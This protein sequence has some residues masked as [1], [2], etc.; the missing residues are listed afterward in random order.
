MSPSTEPY[1]EEKYKALMDGLECS[2]I[3]LS[4]VTSFNAFRI[5]SH[6]FMK[7]YLRLCKILKALPCV[8][9]S[10]LVLKDIQT[11][12]TPSMANEKY[13]GGHIALIKTDNLHDNSIST[14]FSDYL[15]I[16]GN[17]V[18]SRTSLA[19]RDIITTIIG[20]TESVIA[21]S[22]IIT[23]EYLPA[24]INQN[25]VQI[26]INPEKASPEYIN[27][28]LNTKYG[29]NYMVYLSRQTEQY[30]LNCKEIEQVLVVML[31][32]AFQERITRIVR[33]AQ[34]LQTRQREFFEDAC[35]IV[36]HV[37]SIDFHFLP[38]ENIAIKSNKESFVKN[39]RFD[40]EY[41]QPFYEEI[42]KKINTKETI[43]SLCA[44]N[45]ET[46]LPVDQLEYKYIELSSVEKYGTVSDTEVLRGH[47]LPS[48]ARRRVYKGQVIVASVE[49]SLQS[50]ALID[51][52]NDNALCSTGFYVLKSETINPETLLVLFKSKP[53]QALLKQRCSGTILTAISQDELLTVPIP[54]IEETVQ[55]IIASKV[56]ESFALRMQSKQL[57]EY[58]KEAVEMAIEQGE[59]VAFAW[60]KD[61]V[62]V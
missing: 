15:S 30:N 46:Y 53:L 17:R 61:R 50:C 28:Y 35:H 45:D 27:I 13:Y 32:D 58:A 9:L 40:A 1:D 34:L 22:A 2:E 62:G 41:Y 18:I 31:S 19:P 21:R 59:A 7:K 8:P 23:D 48:R 6:F 57:L 25:I 60:L 54:C 12:H 52:D 38:K 42:A 29:K 3:L 33:K 56:Q 16:E 10:T 5:D 14:S 43:G 39:G 44:I 20:A 11:G 51:A 37:L 36:E 24:N 47:E 26:R 49:G 4:Q 55:R